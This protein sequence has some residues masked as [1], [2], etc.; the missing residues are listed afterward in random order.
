M[1]L[2]Q[3]QEK[4][5]SGIGSHHRQSCKTFL[6]KDPYILFTQIVF[7]IHLPN[8]E[9]FISLKLRGTIAKCN[10]GQSTKLV[11]FH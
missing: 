2:D 1:L 3:G 9:L 10:F 6:I 11:R 5:Q 4:A 8:N 7:D